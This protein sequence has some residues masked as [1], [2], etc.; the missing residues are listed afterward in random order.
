M[1]KQTIIIRLLLFFGYYFILY[2]A[3]SKIFP[4][5]LNIYFKR[6]QSTQGQGNLIKQD[7]QT[8]QRKV[9]QSSLYFKKSCDLH[10]ACKMALNPSL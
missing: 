9:Y 6:H 10:N 3:F 4:L 1:N 2:F 5:E 7:S 8:L